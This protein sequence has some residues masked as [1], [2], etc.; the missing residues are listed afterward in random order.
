MAL[1]ADVQFCIYADKV[2][3]VKNML[4][5]YRDG[6]LARSQTPFRQVP[7]MY[8]KYGVKKFL[9]LYCLF[10]NVFSRDNSYYE[11]ANL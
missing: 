7:C 8:C 4:T 10:Q 2:G 1:F 11:Y 5:E 3:G 9:G 6:P